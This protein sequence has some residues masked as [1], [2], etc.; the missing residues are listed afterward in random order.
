MKKLLLLMLLCITNSTFALSAN[1]I[2]HIVIF[3]DSLSDA[4]YA[5]LTPRP[6]NKLATY[7]NGKVWPQYLSEM[8]LH[9]TITAN[10]KFPV[11][12]GKGAYSSGTLDGYDF[13]AGGATT[14]GEGIS[15]AP[16]Y[17]QSPSLIQQIAL[18]PTEHSVDPNNLYIIWIGANDL[19]RT[20]WAYR[21]NP[22]AMFF[23]MFSTGTKAM[24]VVTQQILHLH[25]LGAKHIL[26]IGV[27]NIGLT[28]LLRKS[29][30]GQLMYQIIVNHMDALLQRNLHY[31][32][33][34]VRYVDANKILH[35]VINSNGKQI[36]VAKQTF[37]FNDV[38]DGACLPEK[39][40]KT[41]ALY[42]RYRKNTQH[43][44]F[45]DKVHPTS[46]GHKLIAVYL[47]HIILEDKKL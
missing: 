27:P 16:K 3:G 14:Y 10:N 11:I 12:S 42:C 24:D 8:L 23:S 13:A 30:V 15:F 4:G 1:K 6:K 20:Y 22:L 33:F 41:L 39:K 35:E 46:Y 19:F 40:R 44:L 2:H 21:N 32:P 28:P 25:E 34:Y 37:T 17:Y 47:K 31:L 29:I 36:T 45:A 7:S 5:N 43:Y 38:K 9:K 18:Y 26:V